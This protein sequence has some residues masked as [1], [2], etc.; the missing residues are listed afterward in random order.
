MDNR[1]EGL[2]CRGVSVQKKEGIG[3][4]KTASF[5]E[6]DYFVPNSGRCGVVGPAEIMQEAVASIPHFFIAPDG[7]AA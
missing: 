4:E 5:D 7:V 2:L 1:P 6:A 3:R